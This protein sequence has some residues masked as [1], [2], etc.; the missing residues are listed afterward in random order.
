MSRLNY[1]FIHSD[2]SSKVEILNNQFVSAY[3]REDQSHIPMK[4][5]SVLRLFRDLK[6]H[7]AT[8]SDEVPVFTLKSAAIQ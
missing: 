3:S 6:I 4:G 8:G 2:S 7:K 5:T 1:G